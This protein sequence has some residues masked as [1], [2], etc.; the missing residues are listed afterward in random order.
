M[1]TALLHM[2]FLQ[3]A[4][5]VGYPGLFAVV[6]AESGLF[7]AFFLPGSSMLFAA[8]ILAAG[9]VFNVWALITLMTIAAVMGDNVGYWFGSTIGHSF[10]AKKH[11][12]Q[13]HLAQARDF[14]EKHGVLAVVL[15]RFVPVVRTFA[16]I[17]AGI[18]GMKYRHFLLYNVVGGILWAAG[19]TFAGYYLGTRIPGI[20]RYLTPIVLVIV[21]V[22]SIPVLR[23]ALRHR[24]GSH[25]R[26]PEHPQT[27]A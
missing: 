20:E 26:S 18:A 2:N 10:F 3:L 14:Y 15:A 6:F 7:F 5:V 23:T 4:A 27:S 22:T 19:V 17:V 13:L 24:R 12:R 9:G 21:V 8:G 1:L 16:P 11:S 25:G